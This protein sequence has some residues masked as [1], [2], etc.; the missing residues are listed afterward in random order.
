M[1]SFSKKVFALVRK[2]PKGKVS[3]YKDLLEKVNL[4][5]R[6]IGKILKTNLDP[7]KTPC[8]RVVK[9]NGSLG[10]Y[11]GN[12]TRAKAKILQKEGI[13]IERGKIDLDRYLYKF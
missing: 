11:F 8:H 3:T 4:H 6:T 2:I 10:G 13:E 9:S 1:H 7:I 5:P 12:Q